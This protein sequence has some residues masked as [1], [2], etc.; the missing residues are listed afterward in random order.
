VDFGSIV[1]GQSSA[2]ADIT[3]RNGTDKSVK[4]SGTAIGTDFKIVSNTCPSSLAAGQSC[5]YFIS[6]QPLTIGTK[7]ET[8]FVTA[9]GSLKVNLKGVGTR[10]D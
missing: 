5:D 4:I 3:L 7:N 8:F 1:V 10:G 2:P 9:G 6:F